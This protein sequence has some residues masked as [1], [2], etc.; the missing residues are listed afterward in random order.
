[1]NADEFSRDLA[2]AVNR[3]MG[4]PALRERMGKAGRKRAEE[5]FSWSAIAQQTHDLYASLLKKK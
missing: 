5:H 4:D 2:A 3:L 1:M